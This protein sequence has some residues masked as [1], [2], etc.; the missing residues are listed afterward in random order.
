MREKM[1]SNQEEI[2]EQ[3]IYSNY[4]VWRKDLCSIKGKNILDE[5][6]T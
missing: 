1:E 4:I 3:E 2:E 6:I 5:H